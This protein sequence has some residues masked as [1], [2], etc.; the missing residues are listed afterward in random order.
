MS[1][2]RLEIVGALA[3]CLAVYAPARADE[4]WA[5]VYAHDV[6]PI[7]STRFEHGVDIQLGW[8]G[9]PV[10]ALKAIGRPQPYILGAGNLDGGTNYAAAGLSWRFGDAIYLR[11]GIGMAI[12]DGPLFAVRNG[13]RVDLGSRVL[14]EPE[15]AAGGRLNRC[16]AMELSWVHMSHATLFSRQNRGQD[17]VGIRVVVPVGG[18]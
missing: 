2:R 5:G 8:R 9:R 7:S 15:L 6:T 18:C 12:H 1:V 10:N 17:N 11:P 14:F 4:M 13:R 16:A 3:A